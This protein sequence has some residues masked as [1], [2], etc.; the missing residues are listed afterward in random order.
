[1]PKKTPLKINKLK[2]YPPTKIMQF[3]HK[4]A[5]FADLIHANIVKPIIN[6]WLQQS[7]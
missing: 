6:R 2:K 1:V 4:H 7:A 3:L 5:I